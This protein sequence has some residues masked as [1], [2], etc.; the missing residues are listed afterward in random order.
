MRIR[1]S[2]YGNWWLPSAPDRT[3]PGTLT[4]GETSEPYLE[5]YGTLVVFRAEEG[6]LTI[7]G[8]SSGRKV[9][10]FGIYPTQ[11]TSTLRDGMRYP[12]QLFD[13]NFGALVGDSHVA[14]EDEPKF[15]ESTVDIDYLTFISQDIDHSET[16]IKNKPDGSSD[17]N[18][19]VTTEGRR[20]GR[21]GN[22]DA[23]TVP[24]AS[25]S[26]DAEFYTAEMRIRASFRTYVRLTSA[27]PISTREH[28]ET[29][30]RLSDLV[31]LA[32]HR[33]AGV[34]QIAFND[35]TTDKR[36]RYEW[37]GAEPTSA[38]ELVDRPT[39][40][41]IAFDLG[42]VDLGTVLPAWHTLNTSAVYGVQSIIGLLRET[43][44]YHETKLLGVCGAI[45]A[46][47]R[48]LDP[49]NRTYRQ[50]CEALAAIPSSA[51]VARII[52]DIAKWADYVVKARNSLAHGDEPKDR[53]V[54]EDVWFALHGPTLALLVLVLMA[55]LGISESAQIRAV[56]HGAFRAAANIGTALL[57]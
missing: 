37:W 17:F 7:H 30:R 27:Q 32:M 3:V 14:D 12:V 34:R 48:G 31:T 35:T 6:P 9:S 25:Y 40:R 53:S 1:E 46:L 36:R 2:L 15:S 18:F 19:L 55:E 54:P 21:Y 16:A 51:A 10:L 26:P 33:P 47:H 44:T 39:R 11:E 38:N 22:V 57:N 43:S 49:G 52:P 4:L 24:E 13:I 5:L 20:S 50:R 41:A 56:T 45:E 28:V 42:G 29:A 23:T 8:D